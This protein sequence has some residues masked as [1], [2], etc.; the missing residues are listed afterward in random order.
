M[1]MEMELY[2]KLPLLLDEDFWASLTILLLMA[3]K[4][5]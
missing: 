4:F 2:N 3:I 5:C 1:S